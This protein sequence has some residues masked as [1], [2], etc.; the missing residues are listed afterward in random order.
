[1]ITESFLNSCFSIVL[2]KTDK[3]KK[4]ATLYRDILTV[5]SFY[6]K[7]N[8]T[9]IPVSIK[10]KLECLKKVCELSL[11]GKMEENV[12]D[13]VSLTS[14]YTQLHDFLD[15]KFNEKLKDIEVEDI[16]KQIRLRKK[17]LSLLSN[18][19]KLSEFLDI[20]KDGTFDSTDDIV[21]DYEVMVKELYSNMMT[22]NRGVAIESTA[23][24]DLLNDDYNYA[25]EM[26]QTKYERKNSIP[27][28]FHV[29]DNEVLNGG[30]EPS[31]LYIFGGS[32]GSGKSTLVNNFIV[33]CATKNLSFN[34]NNQPIQN[35]NEI[36]NVY[37]YITLENTIEESLLRTYQ[38]MFNKKLNT[39]L[40]EISSGINIKQ[41]IVDKLQSTNSTIIMKY[42]P[43][44][45]I[46]GLDIMAV[47][48]DV[49]SQYGEGCIKGLYVD[50]LDLLKADTKYDMYRLE[51]GHITLSLKRIAV[52]Y[53]IPVIAPTQLGRGSYRVKES[54][55]LNL[56]LISEAVKKVEHADFVGLMAKDPNDD[57][58]VHCRIGKNRSGKANVNIEFKVNFDMF[59][60]IEGTKTSNSDKPNILTVDDTSFG[61]LGKSEF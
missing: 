17:L 54:R 24:L 26:I 44:T 21:E 5:L 56:D 22:E 45:S 59:K 60:F 36:Q 46:S 19:D 50:Y 38:P 41:L 9:E 57:K 20:I 40:Q 23:S 47:C 12:I 10:P 6:D 28:G 4:N 48:D 43:A 30:F 42:F 32:P 58:L 3:V 53:N 1:M 51:L 14:K 49:I 39:V 7:K 16:V 15:D 35:N 34:L 31:R 55:D 11:D 13:S 27:T 52:D 2:S 61:G 18:Y 33:N 29:L 25:L 8:N 37:I